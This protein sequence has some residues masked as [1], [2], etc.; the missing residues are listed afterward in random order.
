MRQ[1]SL[2][3]LRLLVHLI[4]RKINGASAPMLNHQ[5]S[6]NHGKESFKE[7]RK[8]RKAKCSGHSNSESDSN[9]VA[10]RGST[11]VRQMVCLF[12]RRAPREQCGLRLQD[13]PKRNTLYALAQTSIW[14]SHQPEHLRQNQSR[15]SRLTNG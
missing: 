1:S 13:S 9:S 3:Y 14:S 11:Q 7:S 15:D 10:H 2:H 5:N 8:G 4:A 6:L 12:S